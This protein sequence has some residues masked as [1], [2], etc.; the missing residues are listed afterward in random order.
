[1]KLA[2]YLLLFCA[3]FPAFAGNANDLNTGKITVTQKKN[4]MIKHYTNTEEFFSTHAERTIN[5][6]TQIIRL[7]GIIKSKNNSCDDVFHEAEQLFLDYLIQSDMYYL[8]SHI[9]CEYDPQTD[10]ADRFIISSYFDPVSDKAVSDLTDW[11]ER[12]NGTEIYGY[13][14]IIESAKDLVTS[15]KVSS[16]YKKGIDDPNFL[17]YRSDTANIMFASNYQMQKKLIND[18]EKRFY[19][20][21]PTIVTSF[22]DKWFFPEASKVYQEVFSTSNY[23]VLES[24][25]IFIM[26]KEPQ[27]FTPMLSSNY[28]HTCFD[29]KTKFCL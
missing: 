25:H 17:V 13:P 21:E 6:P 5:Y 8:N 2:H 26:D 23:V 16:G 20:D 1:M 27:L 9:Y 28:T 12:M 10:M 4:V 18:I 29:S 15:L 11:L 14:L 22:F 7:T 19:S 24:N 3:V